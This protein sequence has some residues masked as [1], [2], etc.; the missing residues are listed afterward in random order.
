M[1]RPL[2]VP[3]LPLAS[4]DPFQNDLLRALSSFF[5]ELIG[6]VNS[7][8]QG[9]GVS[10]DSG[11]SIYVTAPIHHVKG[12][13]QIQHIEAPAGFTGPVWL[14]ADDAWSLVTGDN[15]GRAATAEAGKAMMVVYDGSRWYPGA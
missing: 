8:V 13:G 6:Q 12:T 10:I 7:Q 2:A 4:K 3:L 1:N 9:V 5:F 15:I 14:I 11:E